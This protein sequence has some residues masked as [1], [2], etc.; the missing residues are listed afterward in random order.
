[1]LIATHS[2]RTARNSEKIKRLLNFLKEETYSDF[3]TLMLLFG[4]RDH[5]SLYTLLAKTERMGLIQKHVLESR[6]MKMSLWGI[7]SDG[8]AVVL[9]PD[10]DIF[11][12]RFEPS[13]ITGWTLEHH[14]DNQTARIILEQKGASGWINGDRTTFLS[15][16]QVSHRPD[17]LITLPGGTVIAIETERRLKTRA[18]YQSIISSHLLAR[19]QKHWIY[20]FYIVPDHQKKRA[21]EL[22]F[23]SVKHVIINHQHIP[24]EER[25]RRVFRIYTLDELKHLTF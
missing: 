10:D 6:M 4:F 17:G 8:L 23:G 21:L 12:A 7:T 2:E 25:H 16:Y 5:K 3:K 24:L 11:P 18:R 22:L 9:T 1:M 20:V 13:K 15:R 19:T 14:L